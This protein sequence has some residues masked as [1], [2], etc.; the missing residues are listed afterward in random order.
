MNPWGKLLNLIAFTYMDNKQDKP[1]LYFIQLK[2]EIKTKTIFMITKEHKSR[3]LVIPQ[4]G[5]ATY[6]EGNQE[7]QCDLVVSETTWYDEGILG[8]KIGVQHLPLFKFLLFGDTEV[9]N[10]HVDVI[11]DT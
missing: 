5:K 9:K 8:G 2:E 6:R 3:C 7:S 10:L 11:E 1:T 4:K